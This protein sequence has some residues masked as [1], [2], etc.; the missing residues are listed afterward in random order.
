MPADKVPEGTR[1][2]TCPQCGDVFSF[3]KPAS[4]PPASADEAPALPPT[5]PPQPEITHQARPG[6]TEGAASP[7]PAPPRPRPKPAPRKKLLD[8]GD[9]FSESWQLFQRRFAVLIGLYLLTI[10]AFILPLGVTIG[11]AMLA[12]MARGGGAF[13]AIGAVGFLA[14]LYLGFR[15]MAS[16]LHGVVDDQLGFGEA[17]A[18]GKGLVLP[19]VWIGFL[20][21]FIIA[22]GFF[23]LVIPGIVFMVWFF[24]AQFILVD[25][26]IHGM[27]AL[28]KSREYVRGEWFNVGLRLLLV[29]AASLLIGMVPMAGPLL[30]LAFF[31]FVMIFHYLIYRDLREMK[32]D[33]P[34][35]CGTVDILRWPAVALLGFVVVPL[36]LV[37]FVGF[38]LF[39]KFSGFLP[40]GAS[41]VGPGRS[42][43][44]RAM[45]QPCPKPVRTMPG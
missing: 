32:G 9:L 17:L 21:S 43:F 4:E 23:L 6:D 8:I 1:R 16:F 11:V 33:I 26:D 20:S 38:S 14:G 42:R 30:C 19:L 24:F 35:S 27:G 28:L 5:A 36:A 31:P 2:V 37:S 3:T 10:V 34:Y 40:Q 25:E 39:G 45:V 15:C 12:G 13:V 7:L 22:G 41:V 18:R 29:W 44:R